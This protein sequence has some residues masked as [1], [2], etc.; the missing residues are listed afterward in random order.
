[1]GGVRV[2]AGGRFG[3]GE[4]H[5]LKIGYRPDMSAWDVLWLDAYNRR[6]QAWHEAH[7]WDYV[8]LQWSGSLADNARAWAPRLIDDCA[9][10]PWHEPGV[11]EGKNLAGI[12]GT[13]SWG[14]APVPDKV[15][16][17]F[18]ERE[19]TLPWPRN[20]HLTQALWRPTRYVG[21]GEVVKDLDEGRA[22]HR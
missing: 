15:C 8:P 14:K 22:C 6:R 13:G 12:S 11:D 10:K 16:G 5:V 20:S 17:R 18:I 19:E 1:M 2:V 9:T 4:R 21:C 3:A 7:G